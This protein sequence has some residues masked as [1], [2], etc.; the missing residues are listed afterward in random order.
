M[1]ERL[2]VDTVRHVGHHDASCLAWLGVII[3]FQI[4]IS[5]KTEQLQ[6]N[7]GVRSLRELGI[8]QYFERANSLDRHP[9]SV[10]HISCNDTRWL[11]FD[12]LHRGPVFVSESDTICTAA[13]PELLITGT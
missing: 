4:C 9:L 11:M 10:K 1:G 7:I 8:I 2:V 5:A 13:A 3:L 12:E 6:V